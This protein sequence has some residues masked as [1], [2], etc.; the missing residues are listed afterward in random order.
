MEIFYTIEIYFIKMSILCLYIRIFPETNFHRHCIIT[1]VLLTISV[2]ILIPMTIWQ[3][4]PI[5]A[6][7]DLGRSHARCL[8]L[9][10]LAYAN[11]GVNLATEIAILILPLPL[12]QK[13]R[14]S[15]STKAALY[16]MFG[17]G[18]L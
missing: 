12:L 18:I 9:P 10:G 14:V 13:L 7:W 15:K 11:A 4:V 1:I 3:C 16:A 8:S 5:H 2:L 6:I 17:T